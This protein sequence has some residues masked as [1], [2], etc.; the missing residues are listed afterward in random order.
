M[1]PEM[2]G[3]LPKPPSAYLR[4]F[5]FDTCTYDPQVIAQLAKRIGADRLIMGGD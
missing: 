1:P 3:A 4:E 5:Y 2:T